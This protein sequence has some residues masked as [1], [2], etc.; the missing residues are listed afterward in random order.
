[1]PAR[2]DPAERDRRA[3]ARREAQWAKMKSGAA[4]QHFDPNDGIGYGSET[5]W[6]ETAERVRGITRTPKID[7]DLV[8]L[9]LNTLTTRRDLD[10]AYRLKART[11]H[12]D[13]GGS[14]EAMTALSDAYDRLKKR[15][16]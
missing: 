5:Q 7:D 14:H 16:K 8:L 2:L 4:Y 9:G 6:T 3:K 1:M 10:R 15:V 13:V 12:P 11:A